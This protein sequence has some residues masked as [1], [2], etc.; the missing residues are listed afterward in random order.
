LGLS[1]QSGQ[2]Q[3]QSG[4]DDLNLGNREDKPNPIMKQVL[5]RLKPKKSEWNPKQKVKV[6]RMT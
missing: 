6:A 3:G 2:N 1:L 5:M 4:Q